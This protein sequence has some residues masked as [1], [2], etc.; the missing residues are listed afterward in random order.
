MFAHHPVFLDGSQDSSAYSIVIDTEVV[1]KYWKE[2]RDSIKYTEEHLVNNDQVAVVIPN[3]IDLTSRF[4]DAI[5]LFLVIPK[6]NKIVSDILRDRATLR[7]YFEKLETESV[8]EESPYDE[9]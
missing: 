3:I 9:Q 5:N 1:N 8:S 6:E 7:A 4:C 2:S